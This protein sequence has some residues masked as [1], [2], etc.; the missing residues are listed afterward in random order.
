[1]EKQLEEV[2]QKFDC[3]F[4]GLEQGSGF[5]KIQTMPEKTRPLLEF[6]C[7]DV[8]FWLDYLVSLSG[9]HRL[10]PPEIISVHY[11]L[12]S[13][14]KGWKIHVF[15]EQEITA[16]IS[17]PAFD[18][19]SHI[20]KTANWHERET[21]E[22]FGIDFIGH[23]DPR[24]LLLPANWEGFPLRKNYSEQERYHGIQVKY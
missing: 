15:E 2:C 4:L 7:R 18:S 1:M 14:P 10:G 8:D 11:H 20:W 13:I 22:L 23:P 3:Q 9:Y 21:A 12:V 5:W 6:L 24:N 19:V 17:K 16:Q